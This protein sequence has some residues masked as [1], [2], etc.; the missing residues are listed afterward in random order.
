MT[1]CVFHMCLES[2][3]QVDIAQFKHI[4]P[5]AGPFGGKQSF[6]VGF[7]GMATLR[8][9]LIVVKVDS[10]SVLDRGFIEHGVVLVRNAVL[11]P[12]WTW[13]R[14]R[15]ALIVCSSVCLLFCRSTLQLHG[16]VTSDDSGKLT[17]IFY[18]S[19]GRVK[20]WKRRW[21]IL[22]D[23]CLYYFEYTTVSTETKHF[24]LG[25]QIYG[26]FKTDIWH[27]KPFFMSSSFFLTQ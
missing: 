22:T 4:L 14:C 12:F 6:W 25:R 8:W 24:M 18:S 10:W 5:L 7:R 1:T 27:A 16:S 13:I 3:H 9:C 26:L 2:K 15:R 20:T 21:F 23:N 19:G 17:L 11:G